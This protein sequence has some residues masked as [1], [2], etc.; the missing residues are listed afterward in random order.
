MKIDKFKAA[1]NPETHVGRIRL[2]TNRDDKQMLEVPD[3]AEF[4]AMVTLLSSS[5]EIELKHGWLQTGTE[6]IDGD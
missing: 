2:Y 3:A 4:T 1:W 6:P 5:E